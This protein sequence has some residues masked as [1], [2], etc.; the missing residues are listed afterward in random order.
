M[1]QASQP[2]FPELHLTVFVF[3][4]TLAKNANHVDTMYTCTTHVDQRAEFSLDPVSYLREGDGSLAQLWSGH[5][6]QPGSALEP[7]PAPGVDT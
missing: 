4:F 1:S 2:S 5:Q 6:I 3:L 7:I